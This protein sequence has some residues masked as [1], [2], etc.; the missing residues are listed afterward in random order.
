MFNFLHL[1]L[2]TSDQSNRIEHYLYFMHINDGTRK[3]FRILAASITLD[4]LLYE[5]LTTLLRV[6]VTPPSAR[7][8]LKQLFKSIKDD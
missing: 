7:I 5:V 1:F 3:V 6:P 8:E 2:F 4:R